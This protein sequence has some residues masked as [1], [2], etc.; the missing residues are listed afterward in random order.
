MVLPLRFATEAWLFVVMKRTGSWPERGRNKI[1]KAMGYRAERE[2]LKN[3]VRV[4]G[5][6]R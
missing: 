1:L 2:E 4:L 6:G 3:R 5:R